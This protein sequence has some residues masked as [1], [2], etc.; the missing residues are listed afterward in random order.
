M[1]LFVRAG[2]LIVL[3]ALVV[4]VLITQWSWVFSKTVEGKLEGVDKVVMPIAVISGS[5]T[6]GQSQDAFSF[7]VAIRTPDGK[8][9][10]TS[11]EDQ[12]WSVV[13]PGI[14]VR[15][16]LFPYPPWD[17]QKGGTYFNARLKEQYDCPNQ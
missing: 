1:K 3:V 4:F 15:A 9:I 16:T 6:G 11:S 13:K 17:L 8:I 12:Q 10:T 2:L 7:A 14:C 5:R